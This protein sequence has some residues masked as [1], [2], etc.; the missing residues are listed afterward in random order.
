MARK[1]RRIKTAEKVLM[2]DLSQ[3][4]E[5]TV[6]GTAYV[7][8]AQCASIVNRVS[9]RQGYE[10]AVQSLEIGVK[11]GAQFSASIHRLPEHWPCIN[12]WEKSMSLWKR[13]QDEQ[14]E[15]ASLES[16]I[17]AYRDFKIHFDADHRSAGFSANLLPSGYYKED[18]GA[19]GDVYE[20]DA[21]EIVIPN[22]G[23]TPGNTT[24]RTLH[25]IGADLGTAGVGMIKAYAE[26]RARPQSIDP[27][28]VD[29]PYGGIFGQM[30]DVGID[31]ETI[32]DNFQGENREPPYLTARDTAFEYYPGGSFQGQGFIDTGGD[33]ISGQMLD[34]LA[35]NASQNYNSDTMGGFIS[36]CGLIRIDYYATGVLPAAPPVPGNPS[37]F[38]MKI[39][40]A[41]GEYKGL[42]ARPMQEVN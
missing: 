28:I 24:E 36:P 37:P 19:T 5:D 42:M 30:F 38:W 20:W 27:N 32:V 8:L 12:A 11:G 23:G 2:F 9:F 13:Q 14:A 15:E 16:T 41:P 18:A 31:D 34:V 25:M 35:V 39:V 7:D 26:S 22:D 33:A 6:S 17:A 4:L 40:L 29:V 3:E 21:S 10:Y 1:S